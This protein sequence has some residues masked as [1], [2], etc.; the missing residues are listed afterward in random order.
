MASSY[1]PQNISWAS[2]DYSC[3]DPPGSYPIPLVLDFYDHLIS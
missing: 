2:E 1:W 3:I